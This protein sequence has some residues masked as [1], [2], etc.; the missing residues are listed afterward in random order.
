[1][2]LCVKLNITDTVAEKNDRRTNRTVA[3]VW[4]DSVS[5]NRPYLLPQ[6]VQECWWQRDSAEHQA[7]PTAICFARCW[8]CAADLEELM[9]IRFSLSLAL[10]LPIIAVAN[11]S[12][13]HSIQ[14]ADKKNLCLGLVKNQESYCFSVQES[15]TKNMCLAQ[16]KRQSSYCYSISSPD[17]KNFCLAITR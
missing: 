12:Y 11:E 7:I 9:L 10:L 13:C 1:M 8:H 15:A 14:S 16:V 6:K 4:R 2:V 5:A 17:T 3:W